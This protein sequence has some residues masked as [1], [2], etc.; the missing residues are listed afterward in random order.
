MI[1][2]LL[3]PISISL[4]IQ[5]SAFT[6]KGTSG[7]PVFGK[8]GRVIAVN[9]GYYRGISKVEMKDPETGKS[10]E[11]EISRDLSGYAFSVRIDPGISLMKQ[12]LKKRK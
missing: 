10:D 1:V 3:N 8:E 4:L 6:T 2:P 5:H 11:V 7:S 9:S 12:I